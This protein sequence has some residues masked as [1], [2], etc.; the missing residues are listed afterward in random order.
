MSDNKIEVNSTIDFNKI[1]LVRGE[2]PEGIEQKCFLLCKEYLGGVWLTLT[3]NEVKVKRVS[4]GLTNQLYYC[5]I[6][7][8]KRSKDNEEPHE[9]AIRFYQDKRFN[10]GDYETNERLSDTVIAIMVSENGIGPKIYGIFDNGQIQKYY[11]VTSIFF[12]DSSMFHTFYLL[13]ISYTVP[14]AILK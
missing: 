10:Y 7:E 6:N 12:N 2:T 11:K 1:E 9:V 14:D 5:A 8:D 13:K 3:L 4:G